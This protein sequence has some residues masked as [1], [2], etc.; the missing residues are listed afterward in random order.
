VRYEFGRRAYWALQRTSHLGK[1]L[2][3]AQEDITAHIVMAPDVIL[4]YEICADRAA[5][6][7]RP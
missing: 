3:A 7:S 1:M 6:I 5:S 2:T 4:Y